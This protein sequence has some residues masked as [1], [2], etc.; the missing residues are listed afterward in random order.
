MSWPRSWPRR[1]AAPAGRE[2]GEDDLPERWRLAAQA[3]A[4]PRR[5]DETIV[6]DEYL[7]P[8]RAGIDPPGIG[9]VERKQGPRRLGCWA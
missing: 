4:H 7:R 9:A 2:I 5:V 1:T 3:A 6:L 8:R